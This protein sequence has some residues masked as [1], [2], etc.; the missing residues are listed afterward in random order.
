MALTDLK[1]KQA[2]AKEKAYIFTSNLT[3]ENTGE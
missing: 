1:V 3:V 2:K